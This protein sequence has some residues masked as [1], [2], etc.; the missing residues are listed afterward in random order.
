MSREL[1]KD[2]AVM[3]WFITFVISFFGMIIYGGQP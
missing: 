2:I 1:L 3:I